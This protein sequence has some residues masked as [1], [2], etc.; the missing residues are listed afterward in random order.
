MASE[1]RRMARALVESR[2]ETYRSRHSLAQS[3]ARLDAGLAR[4]ERRRTHLQHAWR[5]DE[6]VVLD[7][8]FSAT[9]G[10]QRLLKATS[11]VLAALVAAG[12][13]GLLAA[14]DDPFRYVAPLAAALGMLAFPL[15]VMALG[16]QREAEEA[17]IRKAIRRALTDEDEPAADRSR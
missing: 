2:S 15:V 11:I 10:T 9:P 3:Q 16:S 8:H 12:A 6:G 5:D 4:I 13:W 7:A 17:R 1:M 14:D